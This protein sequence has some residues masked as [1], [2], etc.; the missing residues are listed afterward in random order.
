MIISKSDYIK[1]YQCPKALW[2]YKNRKDLI[3]PDIQEQMA[4]LMAIGQA[5]EDQA[6]KL[7]P[8][9][10]SVPSGSF[11]EGV[12][13]TTKMILDKVP[14]IFQASFWNNDLYCRSDIINHNPEDD[15]WDIYEVKSATKVKPEYLP[16]L[17]FQKIALQEA[18][19]KVKN[20]LVIYVNNKYVRQGEIEP[21]K[22]L[23][24]E[25]VTAVVDKLIEYIRGDIDEIYGLIKK[26]EEPVVRI[27]KQCYDPYPCMFVEYCWKDIPEH[28]IYNVYPSEAEINR[29]LDDN[30]VD[31]ADVPAGVIT[32]DKYKLYYEAHKADKVIADKEAIQKELNK[33]EYPLYFLDYETN[34]P[35][36]PKYDGYRPYQR[37]TFQYSLHVQEKPGGEIKHYEYLAEKNEDPSPGLAESLRTQIGPKG[38]VVAWYMG[39]EAGCNTEMGERYPEHAEFFAD[40]NSR[41]VDLME[42]F[43]KG[44]Y[45]DKNFFGSS[46]LKKVLPVIAP[47]LSYEDLNIQEGMAASDS[48]PTLIGDE[49]NEQEKQDLKNDMLKYCALDT[50]AMVEIFRVLKEK[51]E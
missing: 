8:K 16:D 6:Y 34:S 43:S 51:V 49:L 19:L 24:T 25:D 41:L 10:A 2:L 36:V 3:P 47:H 4:G 50:F 44:Y 5:A 37:M 30:I 40:V 7:F 28:N 9:G 14:V 13:N 29:L 15:T 33:Y 22:L 1:Y 23:V 31:L 45:V 48:W 27:V 11:R 35:G 18:G 21:E 20:T 42:F 17:A 12:D 39:F 46:S 26:R 32:K 38:S